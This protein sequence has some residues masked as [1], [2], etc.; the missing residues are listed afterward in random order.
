ML[1]TRYLLYKKKNGYTESKWIEKLHH[2]NSKGFETESCQIDWESWEFS[3][4]SSAEIS[5]TCSLNRLKCC[6]FVFL[7]STV[8]RYKDRDRDIR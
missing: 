4:L 1:C 8:Y 6:L 7:K 3:C 2:W 5:S